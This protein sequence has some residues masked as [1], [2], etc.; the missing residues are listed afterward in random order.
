M[1]LP[2]EPGRPEYVTAPILENLPVGVE[3]VQPVLGV[4]YVEPASER[5]DM[6]LLLSR[7]GLQLL[8]LLA[9]LQ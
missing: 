4:E 5:M 7:A 3:S 2:A 8:A 6:E 9:R 1:R